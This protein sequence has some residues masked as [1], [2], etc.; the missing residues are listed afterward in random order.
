VD[1]SDV[2]WRRSHAGA[3]PDDSDLAPFSRDAGPGRPTTG[4]NATVGGAGAGS[5]GS[6]GGTVAGGASVRLLG[7][8]AEAGV[9]DR[10][11]LTD[12]KPDWVR[13]RV[14]LDADVL[15]VKRT[16]RDLGLV[17]VCEE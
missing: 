7:R 11:E 14:R 1:R 10:V 16:V 9:T 13:A 15:G 12:R 17:T 2:V 8:L 3:A 4:A 5:G 6:G